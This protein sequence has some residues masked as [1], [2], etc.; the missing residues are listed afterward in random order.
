MNN[1]ER[2]KLKNTG[3]NLILMRMVKYRRGVN[4]YCWDDVKSW[5]CLWLPVTFVSFW[6]VYRVLIL[7]LF[8]AP[9]GIFRQQQNWLLCCIVLLGNELCSW[10]NYLKTPFQIFLII[11]RRTSS[12]CFFHWL[13]HDSCHGWRSIWLDGLW[14]YQ[15]TYKNVRLWST[16]RA[17]HKA[18]RC[19]M[20]KLH[21]QTL[22]SSS[23]KKYITQDLVKFY[24]RT[25]S[26]REKCSQ[27]TNARAHHLH[28]LTGLSA[29][30]FEHFCA[31]WGP[32]CILVLMVN[33]PKLAWVF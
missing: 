8:S 5:Y 15:D 22:A 12:F 33:D 14:K 6:A 1:F 18:G 16:E 10:W 13:A 17:Q 2:N 28:Q 24:A 7:H 9:W 11:T 30:F 31:L 23:C 3:A 27:I 20:P 25:P 21:Y 29:S 26:T 4:S 19:T 32:S